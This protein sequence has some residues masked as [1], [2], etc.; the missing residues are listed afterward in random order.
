MFEIGVMY[1]FNKN[2]KRL[3]IGSMKGSDLANLKVKKEFTEGEICFEINPQKKQ[4][5]QFSQLIQ[6]IIDTVDNAIY[7]ILTFNDLSAITLKGD[8]EKIKEDSLV[9]IKIYLK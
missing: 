2:G 7:G 5:I 6:D 3:Y 4:S 8:I 9:P 1:F